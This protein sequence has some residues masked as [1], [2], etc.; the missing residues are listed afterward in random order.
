MNVSAA[1]V[2]VAGQPLI[3]YICTFLFIEAG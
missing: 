3:L 2:A 1:I